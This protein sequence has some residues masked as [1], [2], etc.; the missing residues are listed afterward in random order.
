MS[1]VLLVLLL[2]APSAVYAADADSKA[3]AVTTSGT[4]LNVR[5]SPSTGS[6]VV[7]TLNKGSYIT[8]L[9]RS[10]DWWR[11]EYG[12]GLYGYCH[13]DYITIVQ[14]TPTTVKTQAGS[15]NVRSGPGT[16]YAKTASLSKGETV[17]LLTTSGG[18]SRVLYHGTK[19]GYV[20][21]QYL[22]SGYAPVSLSVPSF[23]QTDS[24]WADTQVAL[25][26]KTFAQIGCAT[27]AV[28]MMESYRTGKTIYPNE[29]MRSLNYTASGDLYWPS[30]YVTV[31]DPSNYLTRIY[32]LLQQ[33][34]PVLFGAR[35]A[36]GRQHWVVI[37]G[38]AGG[39]A[40]TAASFTIQDPG[41]YSRT[42]LQQFLNAYP[43]VY[44]YFYYGG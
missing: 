35:N 44:K 30:H 5:K 9:S 10:G 8:L 7:A 27:T 43:T 1:A 23:K 21:A 25:S 20:S 6:A 32:Q 42:N 11:V 41:T 31:T 40:L 33:G 15:L 36:Y 16:S 24:R 2:A 34:K 37:T 12:K 4:R 22:A 38:F 17:I 18:W 29:M 26:G 39:S 13:K 14:G 19:T 3:G 28:A